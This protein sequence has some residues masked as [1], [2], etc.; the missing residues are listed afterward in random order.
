MLV[1]G[2]KKKNNK[3][4]KKTGAK[5]S[6]KVY[7]GLL[8]TVQERCCETKVIFVKEKCNYKILLHK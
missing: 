3:N 4:K 1:G 6:R 2:S 7:T 5:F 8:W